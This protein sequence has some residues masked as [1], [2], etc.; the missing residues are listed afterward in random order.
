MVAGQR[1]SGWEVTQIDCEL[2]RRVSVQ[3]R[4]GDADLMLLVAPEGVLPF[5][6]PVRVSRYGVYYSRRLPPPQGPDDQDLQ[7]LLN[8]V[9]AQIHPNERPAGW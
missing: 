8:A 1:L 7:S 4:K 5:P 3:F 6:A 2:P 9:A